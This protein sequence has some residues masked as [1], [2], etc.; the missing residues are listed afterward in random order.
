MVGAEG[1]REVEK[2]G[3]VRLL[4]QGSKLCDMTL[5]EQAERSQAMQNLLGHTEVQ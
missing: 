4:T 5:G 2:A 3:L 1:R